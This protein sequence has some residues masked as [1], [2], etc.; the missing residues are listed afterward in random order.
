MHRRYPFL[1]RSLSY[2]DWPRLEVVVE[3][4]LI[5]LKDIFR[6]TG[7]NYAEH[8]I[9]VAGTVSEV[10]QD[11]TLMRVAVLH[12][13]FLHP[14]AE[15]LVH[16]SPLS[17]DEIQ[18]ARQMHELRRLVI[19]SRTK[20]LDKVLQSFI[21]DE[22]LFVLRMAHRLAD[23]RQLGHF[24]PTLRKRIASE[25]LHM[26][27]AIAS[28]LGMHAWRYEM[29]DRCFKVVHP[30]IARKLESEFSRRN[31]LDENCLTQTEKFIQ[32][33]LRQKGIHCHTEKRIKSLYSTYRKIILKH[34]KFEDLTDRLA[35]RIIVDD[36]MDCYA[37]L[38]VVHSHMHP[39]PGKLKDYI[40]A[41]KENSYQSIH[42]VVYPLA[43]VTEQP[44]EIQIRTEAMDEL[45]E[46]GPAAHADYKKNKYLITSGLGKVNLFRNLAHLRQESKTPKQFEQALRKYFDGDHIAIFDEE[47]NLYHIKKPAT[48]MDFVRHAFPSRYSK[49]K[50]IRI[51]GRKS[52]FDIPLKDGD[53]VRAEFGRQNMM[54]KDKDSSA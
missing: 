1:F 16:E 28:R 5:H 13:I 3:Y 39:I 14:E 6:R 31:E 47:D 50:L 36:L 40:G 29:E 11:P 8:G 12:D 9:S 42:T 7:E 44:I 46:Y 17:D 48:A 33:K 35:L 43:G 51:N 22:R 45:C 54:V 41:P 19:D 25:T 52:E 23:V 2:Q 37:A 32:Q 38:G 49:I 18:L 4:A 21:S 53:I 10:N 26:Y 15:K 30:A 34:R 27:T 24:E 20:D